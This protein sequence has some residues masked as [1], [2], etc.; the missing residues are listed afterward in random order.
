MIKG[1]SHWIGA[2]ALL[3]LGSGCANDPRNNRDTLY[4]GAGGQI[5]QKPTAENDNV[6]YWDGDGIKG[7]SSI[8]INL[9][10]QR[11]YFYKDAQLVGVS[12]IS[13]GR[14]GH[15]T[16][17]GSYKIIQKDKDHKSSLYGDY[18]DAS[19]H[20]IQKDIE[21]SKDPKPPGAIFDGAKM[22]NFMRIVGGT[23]LHAGFLPGYAASHGCIRMPAFMSEN[24]FKNVSNGTPV[25][26]LP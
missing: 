20:I 16:P 4:L 17:T 21:L 23:G 11:A 2:L 18:I 12:L 13:S 10:E 24:F 6:S 8:K 14:E 25:T 5:V 1:S 26:I 7:N 19:G 15:D 3:I 22:P 9:S